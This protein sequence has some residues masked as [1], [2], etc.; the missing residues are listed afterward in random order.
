MPR[1]TKHYDR[2][3]GKVALITGAGS[4][5]AGYG[6][7]KAIA[8]LLAKEGAQVCLID[9]VPERA[10]DTRA[11]ITQAGGDAFVFAGDVTD[12]NVCAR[13]VAATLERH[14]RLDILVNNVGV[15]SA[16]R[17][18]NLDE[19]AWQRTMDIN[20]KSAVLMS[21]YALAPM[22]AQHSGSIINIVSIAALRAYGGFA[23]PAS[24]AAMIALTR[25]TALTY[26]PH[27]IRANAV[28]PGHIFTPMVE[29]FFDEAMR[30][31]RINVAPLG[32]KGDAWDVASAVLFLAS[33]E[34]RFITGTCLPVDG[35]ASEVGAAAG[36]ALA[37]RNYG[38]GEVHG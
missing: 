28:A 12:T 21:K 13:A 36:I 4:Q 20:L 10:E 9:L 32:I 16:E 17:L 6:T 22:M 27:G 19:A 18:D 3:T 35:G 2:L 29:S 38:E 23:Y 14:G 34:A 33:D 11:L 5:G 8:C 37:Q 15:A 31:Q 24:K 7:G 30:R 26:G 1:A 25:S